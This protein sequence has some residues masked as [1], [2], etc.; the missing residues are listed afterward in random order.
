MQIL[1]DSGNK[2]NLIFQAYVAVLRLHVCHINVEAQ[3]TD[4]STLLTHSMVLANF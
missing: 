1:I 3:K 2:I 4:G